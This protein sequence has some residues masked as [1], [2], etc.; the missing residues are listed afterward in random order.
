MAVSRTSSPAKTSGQSRRLVRRWPDPSEAVSHQGKA[1]R[2]RQRP[3]FEDTGCWLTFEE[4]HGPDN[5]DGWSD[6]HAIQQRLHRA[7]PGH[8]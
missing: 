8:Q 5:P 1:A 7:R 3:R 4:T 6:R 2:T